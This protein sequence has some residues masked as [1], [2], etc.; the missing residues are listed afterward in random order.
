MRAKEKLEF[1]RGEFDYYQHVRKSIYDIYPLRTDKRKTRD[2]FSEHLFADARYRRMIKNSKGSSKIVNFHEKENEIDHLIAYRVRKEIQNAI[3]DDKTFLYAYNII[4]LDHNPYDNDYK[5]KTVK[6]KPES[7]DSSAEIEKECIRYKEDYPK[8]NLGDYLLDK[9]NFEFYNRRFCDLLM[10]EEWWLLLFNKVY[11]IFDRLRILAYD[12][13][14]AHYLAN[15]VYLGDK[16]MEESILD[17][18]L[19]FL[20]NYKYDLSPVQKKKLRMLALNISQYRDEHFLTIDKIYLDGVPSLNLNE[21]DWRK[22]TKYFNY[23]LITQWVTHP[24]FTHNQQLQILKL[25]KDR[26][27]TEKQRNPYFFCYDL[28]DCFSQLQQLLTSD[29]LPTGCNGSPFPS[30]NTI[31]PNQHKIQL[32]MVQMIEHL[33]SSLDELKEQNALLTQIITQQNEELRVLHE[34]HDAEIESMKRLL[35]EHAEIYNRKGLTLAQQILLFYYL[36]N[37]LDVNFSNSF[38]MQ[39]ARFLEKVTGK[40]IQ[41]IRA[42]LN[43]DFDSK[44]TKKN[45]KI[46]ADLFRELLPKISAKI[47]N[48][49]K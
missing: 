14:K 39:W 17:L 25:I 28:S 42:E 41:N 34:K 3:C 47:E 8:N 10:N 11:E 1:Y 37:E 35:N 5:G 19:I 7:F 36:F 38:K 49:S 32:P 27:L 15:N 22:A 31:D 26:Y 45:L 12:P 40:H 21:V 9:I 46:V 29:E 30:T 20:K 43:I 24:D 4:E 13:F 44:K 6:L 16:Q 48:D 18:L 2:Y 23:K 33:N